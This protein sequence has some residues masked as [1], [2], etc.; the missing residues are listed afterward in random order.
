MNIVKTACEALKDDN[1][2][3]GNFYEFE[4]ITEDEK[5]IVDKFMFT[6]TSSDNKFLEY[7]KANEDWPSGRAIYSN[8]NQSF[9]ITVNEA[10]AH[11]CIH[12]S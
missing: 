2:L 8:H 3:K 1:D 9:V 10:H 4:T 11:V 12:Y 6:K 5:K 7:S